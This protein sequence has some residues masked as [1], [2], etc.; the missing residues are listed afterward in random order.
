MSNFQRANCVTETGQTIPLRL[1]QARDDDGQPMAAAASAGK[2][3]LS[4]G[5]WGTGGMKIVGEAANANT[6]TDDMLI[7]VALP[8]N[9]EAGT[10][11]TFAIVARV[12][13]PLNTTATIDVEAYLS[14]TNGGVGSDLCSTAGQACN[15][16]TWATYTFTIAGA[17]LAPGRTVEVYIRGVA[18]DGGGTTNGKIEIGR[19][20]YTTSTR[21]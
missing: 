7:E 10:D 5:G 11:L 20:Y 14:D 19:V 8:Q 1:T 12:D 2:F 13:T 9:Y 15:S 21:M 18:N 3:G 4:V 17:T 6:K 16:A